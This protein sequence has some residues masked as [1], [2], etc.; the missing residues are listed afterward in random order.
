MSRSSIAVVDLDRSS[1]EYK[2]EE[3]DIERKKRGEEKRRRERTDATRT[4]PFAKAAALTSKHFA[5][6]PL[7]WILR[8]CWAGG[9]GGGGGG[10]T[11][12][13]EAVEDETM[14]VVVAT[15]HVPVFFAGQIE[16]EVS[17]VPGGVLT[18]LPELSYRKQWKEGRNERGREK[19]EEERKKGRKG[20]RRWDERT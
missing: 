20:K 9:G 3:S 14:E 18:R 17:T 13:V 19:R 6:F 2:E 15:G 5:L 10:T 7:G 8:P 4:H 12:G 1:V 11:L 16:S